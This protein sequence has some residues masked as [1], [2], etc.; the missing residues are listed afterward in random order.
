MISIAILWYA[1]RLSMLLNWLAQN[2]FGALLSSLA[3]AIM[4]SIS[5]AVI[6]QVALG[7]ISS[8][9]PKARMV[10][11]FSAENASDE[12]KCA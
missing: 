8:S 9:A 11:S 2:V 6:I 12:T 10:W 4:S 5:L 1:L 3:L 7:M